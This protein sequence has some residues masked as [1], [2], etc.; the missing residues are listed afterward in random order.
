MNVNLDLNSY[1]VD[2]KQ[3]A[4]TASEIATK[5]PPMA[6][7]AEE[8]STLLPRSVVAGKTRR[9]LPQPPSSSPSKA[10]STKEEDEQRSK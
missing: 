5:Q 2:D 9:T 1:F 7:V 4:T 10:Q 6:S 8:G 3:A